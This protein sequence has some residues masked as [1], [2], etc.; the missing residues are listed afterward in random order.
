MFL[1]SGAVISLIVI[2]SI[3]GIV[4]LLYLITRIRIVRQTNKYVVERL[5]AF[6]STWSVGVHFLA[7]FIDK[8]SYVVTMKEQVKDFDPQPVITKDNVTMQI[9]TVVFFQVTDPKLYAYGV[10]NPILAIENLSAT[11][12]RNIIGELDLDE[13]LT[14][15]DII[16]TKMRSILDE[17]TDPWGIK[18]NRVEV[19]NILPPKDIRESMERQMRA[20]RERREKI[21]LA[22]GEKKSQILL[23]EGEKESQILRADAD[24]QAK[25]LAAEA[26]AESIRKVKEAEAA[27]IRMVREAEADGLKALADA[28]ATPE[29]LTLRSYEA[30]K[31]LANGQSTKIVVPS[32]LQNLA[33]LATTVKNITEGKK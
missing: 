17:A 8:V 21:L 27:G 12:L 13:T 23:A 6:H 10:E 29:V 7:P 24:K 19:K 28:K 1:L 26:Q 33:T 11:T 22:E 9:D 31:D 15:R 32:D 30:V 16:N 2:L 18:V 5:G 3:I 4:V 14:S 25:I 20:E